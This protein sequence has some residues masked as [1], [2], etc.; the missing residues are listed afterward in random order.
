MHYAAQMTLF[1]RRLA[2]PA[3]KASLRSSH[4]QS[5]A[6][7]PTCLNALLLLQDILFP[8]SHCLAALPSRATAAARARHA[9]Q[10]QRLGSQVPHQ[11]DQSSAKYIA[12]KLNKLNLECSQ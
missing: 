2:E 11:V 5:M 4:L 1:T 8:G 9:D 6:G 7:L 12:C 3:R 10:V